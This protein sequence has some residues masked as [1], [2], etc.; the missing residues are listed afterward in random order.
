M[1]NEAGATGKTNDRAVTVTV[2]VIAL[3]AV[4]LLMRPW[5]DS[6]DERK[7]A[8]AS[9]PSPTPAQPAKPEVAPAPAP[10]PAAPLPGALAVTADQLVKDYKSDDPSAADDKYRNRILRVTGTLSLVRKDI[11]GYDD[12]NLVVFNT[13]P[14]EVSA[15]FNG[16]APASL[17]EGQTVTLRCTG[18][19]MV[20][21]MPLLAD[22]AVE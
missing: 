10:A 5:Q 19:G 1:G 20:M 9:A 22:C 12:P 14:N 4:V 3:G 21:E 6:S 8:A 17:K 2:V 18:K 11:M 13:S 15:R 16:D 7:P